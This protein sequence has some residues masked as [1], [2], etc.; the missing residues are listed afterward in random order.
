MC[1]DKRVQDLFSILNTNID[2]FV[3]LYNFENAEIENIKSEN[4]L[5]KD[6]KNMSDSST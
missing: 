2:H 4:Q 6:G 5:H 1:F 3:R